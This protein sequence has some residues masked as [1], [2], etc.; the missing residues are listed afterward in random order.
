M[1]ARLLPLAPAP[2]G[3]LTL[4]KNFCFRSPVGTN[5]TMRLCLPWIAPPTSRS[6]G[7]LELA[8]RDDG[9]ALEH[10]LL[11]VG[12]DGAEDACGGAAKIG[13]RRFQPGVTCRMGIVL[14]PLS[15]DAAEE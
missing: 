3:V 11:A 9:P 7:G 12:I 5:S 15:A 10:P 2:T 8:P 14:G 1:S 4:K 13:V 6:F